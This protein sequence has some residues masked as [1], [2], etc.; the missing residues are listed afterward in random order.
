MCSLICQELQNYPFKNGSNQVILLKSFISARIRAIY[1]Q[2]PAWQ[3]LFDLDV[4][5][6]LWPDFS[7][8]SLIHSV[9]A[10]LDSGMT[11][12]T[13]LLSD[14]YNHPLYLEYSSCRYVSQ[15]LAKIPN[16]RCSLFRLQFNTANTSIVISTIPYL[17]FIFYIFLPNY[18]LRKITHTY[19]LLSLMLN[20][21]LLNSKNF[22]SLFSPISQVCRAMSISE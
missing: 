5:L 7:V 3:I 14:Q 6:L 10:P 12:T 9:S 4:L 17:I 2:W 8:Y 13:L 20:C 18:K 11:W 21:K 15:V 22:I 19:C 16:T 1:L